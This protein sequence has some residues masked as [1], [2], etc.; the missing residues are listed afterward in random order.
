MSNPPKRSPYGR[1]TIRCDPDNSWRAVRAM[2]EI[3]QIA[4]VGEDAFQVK[5]R[6]LDVL[7]EAGILYTILKEEPPAPWQHSSQMPKNG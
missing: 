1:Y 7:D 5:G 3:G 6:H 2:L 4:H